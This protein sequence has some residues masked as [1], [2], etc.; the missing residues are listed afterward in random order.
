MANSAEINLSLGNW[1]VEFLIITTQLLN[2]EQM[3]KEIVYL[4][5]NYKFLG[6]EDGN[7]DDIK[8]L[9]KFVRGFDY[10]AY[11]CSNM[12]NIRN[13]VLGDIIIPK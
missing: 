12:G 11:D 2:V 1:A 6:I 3:K 7:G 5:V 13:S 9:I 8:G 10:F 4:Q